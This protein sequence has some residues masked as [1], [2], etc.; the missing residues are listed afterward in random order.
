M[1]AERLEKRN[2]NEES[3]AQQWVRDVSSRSWR[4]CLHLGIQDEFPEWVTAENSRDEKKPWELQGRDTANVRTLSSPLISQMGKLRP[5]KG[6]WL[7]KE[8][9]GQG[10]NSGLP[11]Q[12]D[13]I[14]PI[15]NPK[16]AKLFK[17]HEGNSTW[18]VVRRKGSLKMVV[19]DSNHSSWTTSVATCGDIK[20][21]NSTES[22]P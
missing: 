14:F 20:G 9:Q 18:T 12:W 21:F 22:H 19:K 2:K 10:W 5:Q 15:P 7:R 17:V 6:K 4:R 1:K 11:S 8:S 13:L 16:L 3:E